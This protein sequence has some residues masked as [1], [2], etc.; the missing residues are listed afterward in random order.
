MNKRTFY[1]K[2]L[3]LFVISGIAKTGIEAVS[4]VGSAPS[5]VVNQT[6]ESPEAPAPR[7]NMPADQEPSV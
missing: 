1:I 7:N 6:F 5:T 4:R 3:G 2:V